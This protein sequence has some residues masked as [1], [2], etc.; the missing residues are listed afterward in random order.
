MVLVANT[1]KHDYSERTRGTSRS[2][3]LNLLLPQ[4]SRS[5]PIIMR[6]LTLIAA[7]L[8]FVSLTERVV[9]AERPNVVLLLVDDLGWA[10]IG[11]YGSDLHE[12]PH[13]DALARR[14]M[15][16]TDGYAA[17]AICTPTRAAIMA[18]KYPAR[19]Q[20]TIWHEWAAQGPQQGRKLLPPESVPNLPTTETTLA[21][22]LQGA[23]YLTAHV[24]KWHLGTAAYYPE[25]H[26]FDINIGATFWGAPA[27]FYH[28]FRGPWSDGEIRYIPGLG[29]GKPG[30]YLT[31]RLTDAAV[32]II[33]EAGD[34]PFFLN[35]AYHTVHTP[36]EGKP[37]LVERYKKKLRP[38][39]KHRNPSYA[40]MV[41]SLDESVGR[42]L[43][44]LEEQGIAERTV[45]IFTSDNGGVVNKTRSGIPTTNIPLRSGKGSLYEGGIRVPWIVHW[46]GVTTPGSVSP[47]LI[48]S[49]DLYPTI[50]EIAGCDDRSLW[51]ETVDGTNLVPLF[52]KTATELERDTLYWHYPHYYPTTTPASAIRQGDW[53]LVE[54]FEGMRAELYDLKN[55]LGEQQDLAAN[56]PGKVNSL[57]KQLHRW[58]K[59]VDAGVPVV[60]PK[61][62]VKR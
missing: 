29:A 57:R 10:D 1:N 28:P 53:K 13:I 23:G 52:K 41:Q 24:G 55:D 8:V 54:Y 37:E 5:P 27:T 33:E 6:F 7:M 44:T 32:K 40:A 25:V 4:P 19:L 9:A 12:T 14:G 2:C 60:N 16:F 31:D 48:S 50:L 51:N 58:R 39:M 45:V 11:C 38:G 59:S 35:M 21:E 20:M 34:Q 56:M 36:I 47:E 15:K 26:G 30:D 49:Q 42:I 17:A 61:Y 43:A 46:P 22:V 3:Q 18:G 62:R